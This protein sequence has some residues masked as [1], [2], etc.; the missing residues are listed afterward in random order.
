MKGI[1][2][3]ALIPVKKGVLNILS[4]NKSVRHIE[5]LFT[6]YNSHNQAETEQLS[7]RVPDELMYKYSLKRTYNIPRQPPLVIGAD[8]LH[9]APV[10]LEVKMQCAVYWSKLT[11]NLFVANTAA[12]QSVLPVPS[13]ERFLFSHGFI[14]YRST[15]DEDT[16]GQIGAILG[17]NESKK[18]DTSHSQL[19]SS[20]SSKLDISHTQNMINLAETPYHTES[21]IATGVC[22]KSCQRCKKCTKIF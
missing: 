22:K 16:S 5:A 10:L 9:L 21:F 7:V 4:S 17:L 1:F 12:T 8:L 19:G 14:K 3:L 18:V 15:T 6:G 2:C 11:H 20:G 13:V